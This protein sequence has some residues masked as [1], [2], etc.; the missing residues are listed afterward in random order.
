MAKKQPN[1]TEGVE[2]PAAVAEEPR[3]SADPE[4]AVR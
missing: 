4:L 3:A 2:A 1:P